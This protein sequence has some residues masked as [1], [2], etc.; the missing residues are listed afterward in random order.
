M[1][2]P[3]K[4]PKPASAAKPPR[5]AEGL[6]CDENQVEDLLSEGESTDAEPGGNGKGTS[7][8]KTSRKVASR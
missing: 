3:G 7:K 4:V 2:V 5:P 1:T 8:Q 6:T